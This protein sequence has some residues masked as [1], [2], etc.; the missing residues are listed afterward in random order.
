[1]K[2]DRINYF[3]VGVFVIAIGAA[4]L[5]LVYR[6]TGGAGPTDLY[7]VYYRNVA[8]LKYGT[9]V[10]YEG[11]Q[12][13]QVETIIP[14]RAG[15]AT[16]Y[17]VEF[18]VVKDWRIPEDS[19]A[20]VVASGLLA[21]IS[22][23]IREGSSPN[24]LAAG[25]EIK[26]ADQVNIFA[27]LNDVAA[28]FRELSREGIMPTL[29]NLNERIS[30]LAAEYEDLSRSNV[31]PLLESVRARVDDPELFDDM[32]A[33]LKK[34]DESA[35]RLQRLLSE[36]NQGKV[37]TTLGNV[38]RVSVNALDLLN[39]IEI[40]RLQMH[41]LVSELD[42]LATDNR[43]NVAT[44]LSNAATSSEDLRASMRE[45]RGS[46]KVI[47]EN[48]D[49]IMYHVE[50]SSRNMHEFTREIRENPGLLFTGSPQPDEARTKGKGEGQ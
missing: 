46:L 15:A 7:H 5:V 1:M 28:D 6:L 12:I 20:A 30:A 33:I 40:T 19:V 43:D 49:T 9:G 27:T 10:F 48:I 4:F 34:V 18:S 37:T 31:R 2:R 21:A 36:E 24:A 17:K 32:K 22:I 47:A 41:H 16:R 8:G 50:G 29:K 3:A 39:R 44:A 23:D 25:A 14:E 45:L 42:T 11:F 35:G 26:G 13:G 38:E